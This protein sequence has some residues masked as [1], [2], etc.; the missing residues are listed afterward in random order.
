MN[1]NVTQSYDE[2]ANPPTVAEANSE[3]SPQTL[4]ACVASEVGYGDYDTEISLV[5]KIGDLET[6]IAGKA[7]SSHTHSASNITGLA[8]VATTGEYSSLSGTPSLAT[9]ATSGDYN[10]LTNK[11]TAYTHPATHPASMIA[12]LSDVATSGSYND[13]ADKPTI[14]T[15]P[16]S[17]PANGGNA[18]TVDNMHASEFA[19]ANHTHGQYASVTH[20][21]AVSDITGLSGELDGKADANHTHNYAAS[22][23]SHT[24]AEVSETSDKKIMTAGERTKLEGVEANAN[25]YTHPATHPAS[26]ITG[27]STVAT[28]GSY[29][30]LSD[31]PTAMAPTAHAH[32][33][34]DI[35]GLASALSG[36]AN[37]SHGHA[38]SEIT[39][40]SDALSGKAN[41]THTHDYAASTHSHTQTEVT[42]LATALSGKANA[43]HAH[44]QSEITG[45][46][47]A[48][49]GKANA[50]HT[51]TGFAASSHTHTQA[52]VTGLETALSDLEDAVGGKAD[53]NHTH[54]YA[55][56]SHNHTVAQITG[57]LP[58][59]KGGT[60]ATTAAAALTNLGLTATAAELNYMD[61][62]TSNVQT[63]LDN[64]AASGHTHTAA[65]LIAM[66]DSLFGTNSVGGVEF[67]YG[68]DSGKNLLT[69]IAAMSQ[70]LHTI[71]SISTTEGNP[72]T[73]ESFRC[74]THKSAVGFGWLIAFGALGSA[75]INYLDNGTWS[76]WVALY[77]AT[78]APLWTGTW[79]PNASQTITPTK[80]LSECRNGWILVWGDYDTT[81][82]V[83]VASEACTT[84]IPK[85][86]FGGA[87]WT[88]Q[89]FLTVLPTAMTESA[90]GITI[91]RVQVYDAK[92]TGHAYNTVSP[93]NDI[94]L[95]AVYEY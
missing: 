41:A 33:Q 50:T 76:G 94:V 13:L 35:S 22:A 53:A 87:K 68:A 82:N 30:D 78:P 15:V 54:N 65:E 38:Q 58:L 31:K 23:H 20:G 37:T 43:S 7:A 34:S 24:L 51:H 47:D 62:V 74:L 46:A 6:A 67:S 18:D 73:T 75:Y 28:T 57:T 60:G 90:D 8:E 77:E 32:A 1:D 95:R 16:A 80:T 21:H 63:Q 64:K 89:S 93:R 36:K 44:E 14:P 5:D 79:Y 86:G 61:G 2:Q 55:A 66:A 10:D 56:S 39:G 19:V 40:L 17:L 42:G 83:G 12:G 84:V 45:L 11:P 85:L 29:N 81:N 3:V 88:G 26:M 59:T 4:W 70:G 9:V 71:Y 72:N 69:E 91:K 92:L 48:L 27:L 49:T 25:N 52:Q